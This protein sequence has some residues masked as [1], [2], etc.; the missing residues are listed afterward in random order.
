MAR[1]RT[2]SPLVTTSNDLLAEH[3][4]GALR[5]TF[6]RPH[7]LNAL[8]TQLL[9][10]T[11][12]AVEAA[13]DDPAVRAIVITGAGRGFSSGADL[14]VR[15]DPDF[16]GGAETVE[17]VIRLVRLL[18]TVPKPVVAAV[19]GPAVG[20]GCSVALAADVTV[21]RESAYFLLSFANIGL[22]PD[23]GATALVP[24][25]VGRARATRMAMLAERIPA[26]LAA[27]WG[28]IT[29]AVPDDDFDVELRELT[30]RLAGG[31]TAAYAQTKRALNELTLPLLEQAFA[32]E[33]TGQSTLTR[34]VDFAEGL[35]A[36]L[37]KRTPTFTGEPFRGPQQTSPRER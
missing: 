28:L 9:D 21:A 36:F 11:A 27:E 34:T 24:A 19:N 15:A 30:A 1:V 29:A 23:A 8:T 14:S 37:E 17:A 3:V 7:T 20:G 33:R 4:D 22:M 32:I 35:A 25:A 16:T 31:P 2:E 13:G 26:P 10:S 18:R 12:D 6:N 5:L